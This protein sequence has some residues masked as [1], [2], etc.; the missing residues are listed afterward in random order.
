LP[1]EKIS[2]PESNYQDKVLDW[3]KEALQESEAFL[4]AQPGFDKTDKCIRTIMG[5]DEDFR[6]TQLSRVTSNRFGHIALNL[7]A[8]LTDTK[9]FWEFKTKNRKFEQQAEMGNKLASQWWTGRMIDLRFSDVIKYAEVGGSGYT[10]LTYNREINDLD[11]IGEDPRD[12]LPIRPNSNISLQDCFAVMVRRERTSNYLRAMYADKAEFIKPDRDATMAQMQKQG[13]FA[14]FME[15]VGLNVSP[16]AERQA[17]LNRA[18]ANLAIPTCDLFILY[19]KDPATNDSLGPIWMGDDANGYAVKPG[20]PKYP[21]KRRIIFTRS[22]ILRDEPSPYWHGKFPLSK[23]TLD[24]W[25]WTW[26]GKAPLWDLLPL[27]EELTKLLRVVADRN[28]KVARPDVLGD[29]NSM[30]KAA[31][32]AIDTRKAGLR[33]RS[34]MLAGKGVAIQVPPPLDEGI[35]KS[36][37][38]L[39][40]EMDTISGNVDMSNL[41]KLNQL[42][43]SN[44]IET[45]LSAMTPTI[46]LRSRV[47][48]AFLRE[49]A[50]MVLSNFFQFYTTNQRLSVLG[51]DGLTFEDMDFD[52]GTLIP[53][54]LDSSEH[55][56]PIRARHERAAEFLPQFT[57]QV[58]PGSL[59][60]ASVIEEQLKYLQLARAGLCDHWT[61]LDKLGIPNVGEPPAG[62]NTITERLVAEQQMGLGMAVNPAGRKASGQ[63]TPRMVVKE[64]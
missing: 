62:A 13:R 11:M 12:V 17:S 8:A 46:R 21:R 30:S 3:A 14:Q 56:K 47:M 9:P 35:V 34:N 29:A 27:Q 40:S 44:T 37:E 55:G 42:P 51:P 19:V 1:E 23:L 20:E 41:S 4:R 25:P 22:I 60:S 49:F 15:R 59:L 24:P 64:S 38:F 54:Y 31:F 61:L 48:E 28:Q 32:D 63:E 39:I 43:S 2:V 58:A 7:S 45:I 33:I 26:I 18:A 53:D 6:T 50:M 36:I 57:Y 16:F 10:H 5:T 52:P